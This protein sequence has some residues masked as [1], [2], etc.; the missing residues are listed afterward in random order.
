MLD[1]DHERMIGLELRTGTSVWHRVG[2]KVVIII[3]DLILIVPLMNFWL[4]RP[5][6]WAFPAIFAQ[7]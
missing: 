7:L 5:P 4:H 1:H 2:Q 3:P 6:L